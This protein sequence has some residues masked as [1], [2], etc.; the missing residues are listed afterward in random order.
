[1]DIT[2]NH[3]AAGSGTFQ[4]GIGHALMPRRQHKAVTVFNKRAN[5][6]L[7]AV[8]VQPAFGFAL[9][10]DLAIVLI[11]VAQNIQSAAD[12]LFP[13]HPHRREQFIY[14]LFLHD[15]PD[16][17]E[18]GFPGIV[19]I[20]AFRELFQIYPG[21][22]QQVSLF[23]TNDP[24]IQNCL[25]V[26]G[27][28]KED[29]LCLPQGNLIE[30][31]H[32]FSQK[33]ILLK[34]RTKSGNVRC[35]RHSKHPTGNAPIGVRLDGV[36][37]DQI[38]PLLFDNAYVCAQQPQVVER[39]HPT[40]LHGNTDQ[41]TAHFFYLLFREPFR[42]IIYQGNNRGDRIALCYQFSNQH[43]PK[44]FQPGCTVADNQ[45]VH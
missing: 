41:T 19:R 11:K 31:G 24:G 35:V 36:G 37:N 2:G 42:F 33:T 9:P 8:V 12:A 29:N 32:K 5:I 21:T 22:V 28:L 18:S 39:I 3:R 40:A 16:E 25:P 45:N 1:M 27:I 6:I 34:C 26:F 14:A 10:N 44:H 20:R 30:N 13:Q 43:P 15:T 17:Q 7:I 38:R 23:R 4:I